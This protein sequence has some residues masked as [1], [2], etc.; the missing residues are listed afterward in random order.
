MA[1][2]V[3]LVAAFFEAAAPPGPQPARA[4]AVGITVRSQ[5]NGFVEDFARGVVRGLLN[6]T[7]LG[8][9]VVDG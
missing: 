6:F 5:I 2:S 3:A 4:L 7:F 8:H 9:R 1:W